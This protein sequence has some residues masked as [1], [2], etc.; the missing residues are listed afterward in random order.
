MK[1]YRS[2]SSNR[3]IVENNGK[4][5]CCKYSHKMFPEGLDIIHHGEVLKRVNDK[6]W[7]IFN[8]H[9]ETPDAYYGMPLLGLGLAD[10]FIKKEDTRHFLPEELEALNNLTIGI[11]GSHTGADSGIRYKLDAVEVVPK[12]KDEPKKEVKKINTWEELVFA[13]RDAETDQEVE[14]FIV[15]FAKDYPNQSTWGQML[16]KGMTEETLRGL[17]KIDIMQGRYTIP[18]KE[19]SL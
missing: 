7:E 8:V 1:I 17:L 18:K 12:Y 19:E 14:D 13:L 15:Q 16:S 5:V 9:Y 11:F 2:R 3:K 10:C 6:E 4:V